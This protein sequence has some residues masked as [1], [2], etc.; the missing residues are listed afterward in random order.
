MM[1]CPNCHAKVATRSTKLKDGIKSRIYVCSCGWAFDTREVMYRTRS[2]EQR[3]SYRRGDPAV[4]SLAAKAK[5]LQ[6]LKAS[7]RKA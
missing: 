4:R 5:T 2:P 1:P 6:W 7:G 3:A